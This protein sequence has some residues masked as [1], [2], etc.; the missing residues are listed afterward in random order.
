MH[1]CSLQ[2]KLCFEDPRLQVIGT[3]K[4]PNIRIILVNCYLQIIGEISV[5]GAT[6]KSMEFVGSTV[7]RLTVCFWLKIILINCHTA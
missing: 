7:E 3:C 4:E 1:A 6:Y 5:S 2:I